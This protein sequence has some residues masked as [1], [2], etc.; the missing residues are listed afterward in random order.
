MSIFDIFRKRKPIPAPWSK[1][2]TED[3]LDI[4]IPN[5][6]LYRQVLNT[7]NK[8]PNNISYK[9]FNTKVLYKDFIKK[10]DRAAISFKKL[11]V[12]NNLKF[13]YIAY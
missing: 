5:I 6:S 2:Y 4:K 13:F 12:K 8:Y 1:Y 11:N 10:I 9:Y 7:A 3:E